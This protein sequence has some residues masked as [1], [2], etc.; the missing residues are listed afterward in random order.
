MGNTH[1]LV[2][3]IIYLLFRFILQGEQ[4]YIPMIEYAFIYMVHESKI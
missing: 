3:E 4:K 2:R 1:L